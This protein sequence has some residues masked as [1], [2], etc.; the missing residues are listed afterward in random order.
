M[1]LFRGLAALPN[2]FCNK[3]VFNPTWDVSHGIDD[4]ISFCFV[5]IVLL[6]LLSCHFQQLVLQLHHSHQK[7][8]TRTNQTFSLLNGSFLHSHC[9]HIPRASF[10]Y[11]VIVVNIPELSRRKN[12]DSI[13]RWP[14]YVDHHSGVRQERNMLL[15]SFSRCWMTWGLEFAYSRR[16]S[17]K[18]TATVEIP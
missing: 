4:C 11:F 15:L 6:F 13:H 12:Q 17:R 18:R 16:R 10:C 3:R 14:F 9:P 7:F 5:A 1:F 2:N 8:L